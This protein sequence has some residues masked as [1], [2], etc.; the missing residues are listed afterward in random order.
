MFTHVKNDSEVKGDKSTRTIAKLFLNSLYGK[1]ASHYFMN[2]SLVTYNEED[3]KVLGE[4][5]KINSIIDIDVDMK[6]VNFKLNP[7]VTR[8]TILDKDTVKY[9]FHKSSQLTRDKNINM[10]I[11]STITSHARIILYNLYI[12]VEKIGGKLCYSDTDSVF[13]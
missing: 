7:Q 9:A 11:A 8:C 12:E 10:A 2:T 5:Y 4:L 13:A 1:F 3:I 6:V